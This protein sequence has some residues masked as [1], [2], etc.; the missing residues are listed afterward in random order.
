V[1][2]PYLETHF[3]KTFEAVIV[4]GQRRI[5]IVW[6][7]DDAVGGVVLLFGLRISW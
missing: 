5:E 2:H 6:D 4:R 1:L 3:V 7:A